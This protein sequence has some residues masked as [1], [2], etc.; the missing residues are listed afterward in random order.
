MSDDIEI[1]IPEPEE[2]SASELTAFILPS[3]KKMIPIPLEDKSFDLDIIININSALAR[4]YQLGAISRV[5][6]VT[7][8]DDTYDEAFSGAGE[9]VI[10]L[11]KMLIYLKVKYGFDTQTMTASNLSALEN[12]IKDIEWQ[13][14]TAKLIEE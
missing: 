12:K 13:I 8:E 9:N 4:I 5:Y 2:P 11:G 3:I 6:T 14:S 7:S 1:P 10:N